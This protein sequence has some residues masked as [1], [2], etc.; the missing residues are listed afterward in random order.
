LLDRVDVKIEMLPVGRADLLSDGRSPE[1]SSVVAERVMSAR[2]RALRRLSGT[3]WRLNAEVPGS[4]LRRRFTPAPGALAP[5]ER[6]MELGEISARGVDRVLRV[7]WTLADL[8]GRPRP[9]AE[10]TCYALGLWL[11]VGL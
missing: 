5:L 3:R 10:D 4:E 8:A 2:H 7:S 6:A 11:G 9:G 1:P